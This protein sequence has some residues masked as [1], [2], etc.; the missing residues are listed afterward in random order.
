MLRCSGCR[1]ATP[2]QVV[3]LMQKRGDSPNGSPGPLDLPIEQTA[4]WSAEHHST[5]TQWCSTFDRSRDPPLLE[6]ACERIPFRTTP[7]RSTRGA[8]PGRRTAC[9]LMVRAAPSSYGSAG[10][11][12][13]W[14]VILCVTRRP[15]RTLSMKR[16]CATSLGDCIPRARSMPISAGYCAV[17]RRSGAGT[18]R[19]DESGKRDTR[20]ERA[21]G[22]RG[23]PE[24]SNSSRRKACCTCCADWMRSRDKPFGCATSKGSPWRASQR[25]TANRS[26]A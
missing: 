20:G 3:V 25:R 5:S 18:R 26:R 24:A 8:I 21:G 10:A 16:C 9:H 15:Q 22:T 19:G 1:L 12:W 7:H 14:P 4:C 2:A 13:S 11:C 6:S 17:S 23:Q